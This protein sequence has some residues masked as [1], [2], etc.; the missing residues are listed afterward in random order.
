MHVHNEQR[1]AI[2]TKCPFVCLSVCVLSVY[3]RLTVLRLLSILSYSLCP[4]HIIKHYYSSRSLHPSVGLCY[5]NFVLI[6]APCSYRPHFSTFCVILILSSL[7]C[8]FYISLLFSRSPRLFP[9]FPSSS[10]LFPPFY[11]S[12]YIS[13]YL[14]IYLSICLSVCLSACLSVCVLF[15][16]VSMY[17][18]LHSSIH[19]SL[20]LSLALSLSL[21]GS[22]CVSRIL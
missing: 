2:L 6:L 14:Y 12:I 19:F 11:L 10:L 9:L 16:C 21:S 4:P 13:I 7:L 20:S 15:A 22:S 18:Y 1:N 5:L 17:L 3:V 8:V